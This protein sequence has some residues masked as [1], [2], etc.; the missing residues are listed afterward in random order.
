[1]FVG[2]LKRPKS[3]LAASKSSL[4]KVHKKA[5]FWHSRIVY[6]TAKTGRSF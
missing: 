3:R 1:M 2:L 4:A 6:I 5:D